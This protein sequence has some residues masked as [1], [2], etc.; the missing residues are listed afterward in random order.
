[1]DDEGYNDQKYKQYIE[2]NYQ[3]ED[4]SNRQLNS[5]NLY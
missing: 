1:M 3:E 2:N 5:V 4:P